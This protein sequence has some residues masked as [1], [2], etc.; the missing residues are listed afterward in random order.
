MIL[1]SANGTIRRKQRLAT[2]D[3]SS[4]G[5]HNLQ[6]GRVHDACGSMIGAD[7]H[8]GHIVGQKA[9]KF[10][11]TFYFQYGHRSIADLAHIAMAVEKL[12]IL[13]AIAV[14]DE[15]R[16][17]ESLAREVRGLIAKGIPLTEAEKEAGRSQQSQWKLFDEYGSR[18]VIAAFG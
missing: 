10:L 12:S 9:E 5:A 14:A 13:A 4:A 3:L 11:D 6:A 16:Y 8:L 18:N 2:R 1:F 17:F 7:L 15:Q